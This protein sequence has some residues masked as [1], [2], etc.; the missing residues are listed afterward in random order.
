M[1]TPA[2]AA[3]SADTTLTPFQVSRR[4]PGPHDVDIDIHFCGVCFSDLHTARNEWGGT[5]SPVVPGHEI[6]GRVIR[7]GPSVTRHRPGDLVGVGCFTDTCRN[8]PNCLAGEESYCEGGISWTY[9]STERGRP[10]RT[11][12]GYS[13]RIVADEHYVLRIPGNLSPDRAAPLLCAGIT[14]WS[15]LRHA[16]VGPGMRV[17][18]LGLGGLGHMGVK[19]AAALGAEVT[20]VSHSPQKEADARNLGA[21]HFLL[22]SD[23]AAMKAHK[24]RFDYILNTVSAAH[25]YNR[26]L[27]L[28]RLHGNMTLVGI[29]PEAIPVR[30]NLLVGQ[31]R[32]LS[33]SLIGG[34]RETQEM[35]D[36]CGA[37]G[38]ACD[39]ETIPVDHINQAYERM[40]RSDVRYR[41]VIDLASL[42]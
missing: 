20:V 38:I 9:N 2:Y 1:P 23:E 30:A 18:I 5:T 13:T 16:K 34:I 3:L 35:L 12:G 8:C 19:F 10:E 17:A 28:L 32:S 27:Q 42:K 31:R 7:T 40:L 21:H 41:F 6:I 26:Y 14:T 36:Y 4:E 33:G 22:S 24:N 37:N 11:Y 29:P 25:D 39:V 15:P